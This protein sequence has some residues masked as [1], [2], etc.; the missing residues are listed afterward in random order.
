M[1]KMSTPP[2]L[3]SS[4]HLRERVAFTLIELLVVIAII[5]ILAGLLLPALARAKEKAKAIA[6][7]NN[8]KQWVYAF[9]MYSDDNDEYFPYEGDPGTAINAGFNVDAWYNVCAAYAGQQA[10]QDLYAQGN[11]PVPGRKSIFACPS[12]RKGPTTTPTVTTPYFMY[13]FNNRLDPNGAPRFRRTEVLRPVETVTFTENN[14]STF[15]STSGV[16][17]PARH[18]KRANLGFVDGHAQ[19]VHTNDYFRLSTEDNAAAEWSKSRHVYWF[20]YPTAPN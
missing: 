11:P 13:G 1:Q 20:P 3:V 10:L 18:S 19:A 17:T 14:E 15:P 12:V 9:Y 16:F 7:L 5:A 4:S 8:V 6:S 2:V